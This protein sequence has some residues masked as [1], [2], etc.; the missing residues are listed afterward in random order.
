MRAG[1]V[2]A[3]RIADVMANGKGA[4]ESVTRAKYRAQIVAER[5]TG[6]SQED[7]YE[8]DAMRRGTEQEPFARAAYEAEKSLLVDQV[9]FVVHPEIP[10]AGCSPDGI[11]G[12]GSGQRSENAGGCE[13]KCPN[14]STHIRWII[15]GEVPAEHLKQMH[16]CMAVT[17]AA[18]WD[19]VSFDGRVPDEDLR[20]F[21]RR[22]NRDRAT[23]EAMEAAVREF[24]AECSALVAILRHENTEAA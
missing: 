18:W 16:W 20:L 14:T 23:V 5:L 9:A 17:G 13:I 10:N 24:D 12:D 19:F 6:V 21:V 15:G 2:T 3:S 8:S 4:A 1:K 22:L 11:V 7:G